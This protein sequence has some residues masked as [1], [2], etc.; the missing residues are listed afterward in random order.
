MPPTDTDH[1]TDDERDAIE[2]AAMDEGAPPPSD[3]APVDD[4]P[5]L[6]DARPDK[7]LLTDEELA[8]LSDD[9]EGDGDDPSDAEAGDDST[10]AADAGG[11]AET[12]EAPPEGEV[13]EEAPAA[14]A[15]P[16]TVAPTANDLTPEE[17]AA[18]EAKIDEE[19]EAATEAYDSGD[20]TREELRE[21]IRE[22]RAEGQRSIQSAL[23]EKAN[24]AAEARAQ[25]W[26]E[27]HQAAAKAFLTANPGIAQDKTVLARFDVLQQQ[28]QS[29]P[30][31]SGKD[32]KAIFAEARARL[33][34]EAARTGKTIPGV[35]KPGKRPAHATRDIPPS[36]NSLPAAAP[37]APE[38]SRLAQ[39]ATQFDNAPDEA[40]RERI[41]G[42]MTREEQ[43]RILAGDY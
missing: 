8:A 30:M 21:A 15:E 16:R 35:S 18:I 23:A 37:N 24:A 13:R 40:A 29:D 10:P 22:A 11:E 20:M 32:S 17:V 19:I 42:R 25:A 36:I 9:N 34:D 1:L 41:W 3:E 14:E 27:G 33:V 6:A 7:S 38:G 26:A 4:R 2:E 39:M 31:F 5:W 12:E 43:D 28:V